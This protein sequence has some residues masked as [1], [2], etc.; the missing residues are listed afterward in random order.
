MRGEAGAAL[1]REAQ[2][3]YLTE[4]ALADPKV[5]PAYVE[6]DDVVIALS[7]TRWSQWDIAQ[8]NDE[9]FGGLLGV[10]SGYLY[11]LE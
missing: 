2:S 10:E 4:T 6:F 9:Q 8:M 3:R 1:V 5:G 11:P 7:P